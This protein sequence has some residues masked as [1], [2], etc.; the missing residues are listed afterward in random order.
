MEDELARLSLDDRQ[1]NDLWGRAIDQL[2]EEHRSNINFSCDK[3]STL[4]NLKLDVEKAQKKCDEKRLHC[5][6]K[7]GEKVIFRDVLGKVLKWI[8]IFRDVGDLAVQYDP[9]HAALPWAGV[10]FLLQV[11]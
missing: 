8:T 7:N 11:R 4:Q 2:S 9:G 10:R 5:K 1:T 3:L 6:R